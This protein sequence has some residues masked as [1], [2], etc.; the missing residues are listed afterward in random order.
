MPAVGLV[1]L[2][3]HTT[4]AP[5][6]T[7]F[8]RFRLPRRFLL[9]LFQFAVWFR[10]P[11]FTRTRGLPFGFAL[12][13]VARFVCYLPLPAVRLPVV[14]RVLRTVTF[15]LDTR[16]RLH[17][18]CVCRAYL[19]AARFRF[20]LLLPCGLVWFGFCCVLDILPRGLPFCATHRTRYTPALVTAPVRMPRRRLAYTR[21][22]F[23]V[24][25]FAVWTCVTAFCRLPPGRLLVL[26][27]SFAAFTT[28][29][30][31]VTRFP[32]PRTTRL[33]Y[34][35]PALP[36]TITP[37]VPSHTRYHTPLLRSR[38]PRT[39]YVLPAFPFPVPTLPPPVTA[40][41]PTRR[42]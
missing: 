7:W 12:R 25:T 8:P 37:P 39:V 10:R 9:V 21:A 32:V 4:F 2:G 26:P 19:P 31:R 30:A 16:L 17:T 18:H 3:L 41:H 34:G 33:V 22:G 5:C 38:F 23:T 13:A 1:S 27:A 20:C 35:S 28:L 42:R 40:P 24:V 14:F 6:L 36:H 15:Y 11:S 29:R